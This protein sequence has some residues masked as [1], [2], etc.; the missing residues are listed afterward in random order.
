[1]FSTV[2]SGSSSVG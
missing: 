1:L 2:L